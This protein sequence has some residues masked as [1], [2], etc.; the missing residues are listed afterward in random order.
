[1]PFKRFDYIIPQ[2]NPFVNPYELIL[3]FTSYIIKKRAFKRALT[4]GYKYDII[5]VQS[6]KGGILYEIF[7]VYNISNVH[8]LSC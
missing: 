7:L 4:F 3:G 8:Y 1:M 2:G 6:L 5:D